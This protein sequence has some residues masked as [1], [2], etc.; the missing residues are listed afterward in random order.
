MS[1]YVPNVQFN[2]WQP[3]WLVSKERW[4]HAKLFSM[5]LVNCWTLKS[6]VIHALLY[7]PAMH[8]HTLKAPLKHTHTV[9]VVPYFVCCTVPH[10]WSHHTQCGNTGLETGCSFP[11]ATSAAHS[12]FP[13]IQIL[14]ETHFSLSH[15]MKQQNKDEDIM[16]S[17]NITVVQ[18]WYSF[19]MSMFTQYKDG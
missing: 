8:V 3:I 4:L 19:Q 15:T 2:R 12:M 7:C 13:P 10:G 11:A 5:Q 18:N 17:Y 9:T 16:Q 6:A 14:R 1:L